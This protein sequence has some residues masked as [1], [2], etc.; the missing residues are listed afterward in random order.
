MS[1]PPAAPSPA[2]AGQRVAFAAL[3][4]HDY[5]FYFGGSLLAMMGDNVEHVLNYWVLFQRFHSPVLGGF[6]VMSHWLPS[7]FFS[8]YSGAL[9]DRFD[10]RKRSQ[11]AQAIFLGVSLGWGVL[12]YTN[13]PELWHALVLLMLSGAAG[14]SWALPSQLI[15]HDMVGRQHLQSTVRLNATSRQLGLLFSPGLGGVMLPALGPGV[16]L[17]VNGLLYL[18]LTLWLLTVPYTGH[19]H[20]GPT[21]ARRGV[22]LGE[23]LR[24][25]RFVSADR[26]LLVMISLAGLTSLLVGNSFGAQMPEYAHDLGADQAGLAYSVLLGANAAGAVVGGLLLEGFGL[27]QAPEHGADLHRALVPGDDRLRRDDQLRFGRGAPVRRW[28]ALPRLQ[29]DRPDARPTPGAAGRTRTRDRPLQ[30]GAE[31]AAGG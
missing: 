18:P 27:L 10:C 30:H 24:V 6:A 11:L 28:P 25:L 15:L 29:L 8:V 22:G 4:H 14:D 9:A 12:I 2:V 17:L 20:A 1:S 16:G 3:R 31:W 21:T 5:R 7:L 26:P 23:A 19:G 13:S